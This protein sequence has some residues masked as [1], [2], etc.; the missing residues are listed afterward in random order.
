MY[1][2]VY[3]CTH[4]HAC[5]HASA[6]TYVDYT[7]AYKHSYTHIFRNH[8]FTA[9]LPTQ[10]HSPLDLASLPYWHIPLSSVRTLLFILPQDTNLKEFRICPHSPPTSPPHLNT[11]VHIRTPWLPPN[12]RYVVR[13]Y[14][15]KSLD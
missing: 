1:A 3:T 12:G 15:P 2:C 13:Y 14:L 10:V 11:H 8:E 7:C 5:T 9:L 4:K 6:H